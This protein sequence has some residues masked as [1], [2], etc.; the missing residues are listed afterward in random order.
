MSDIKYIKKL[1]NEIN[2][3]CDLYYNKNRP[4]ITDSEF[5]NLYDE[6]LELERV[7]GIVMSNSPTIN[8]GY[9][10]VSKLNKVEHT[11]PL[12]SLNKTK[13]LD[14]L[15]RFI[16]N[17]ECLMMLKM[18][19][20][21]TKLVYNDG[22]LKQGSTRGSGVIGEDITHSVK[23]F[24]NIP[25]KTN[26]DLTVIGESI[27]TFQDFNKINSTLNE[28]DKYRNP[29]NLASGSVRQLDSNICAK[30]N[31]KFIAYG[32]QD[33]IGKTKSDQLEYLE[34]LGFEVVPYFI[35]NRVNFED[36][37][38]I[39]KN[40][41]QE[42]GFAIDGLVISI[43]NISVAKNMGYT[44][45]F[46]KS[47]IALKFGDDLHETTFIEVEYN[48]TRTGQISLT[49]IFEPVEIDGTSVGRASLHN[50][51]IFESLQ[52]GKGDTILV[53]KANMIIPQVMDN[54]TRSNT[55]ELIDECPVCKNKAEVRHLKDSRQLF[56]TNDDCVA[57]NIG[58]I[59]HFVSRNSMNIVG[60]SEATIEKFVQCG[61]INDVADIYYLDD[62]AKEICKM[63]GFGRK[64]YEKL[65]KSIQ[66]STNVDLANFIN[67]LGIPNVGLSTA[68]T[69]AKNYDEI[70]FQHAN[71]ID[72]L[73]LDDIG[74]TVANSIVNWFKNDTNV[75][76]YAR[77][78]DDIGFNFKKN[79]VK[80]SSITGKSFV[81]TGSVNVFK[82]RKELQKRIEELGGVVKSS[83][84][85]DTDYLIN[86]DNMSSS[87]KNVTAK[88]LNVPII[89]EEEFIKL[90]GE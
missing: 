24:K 60:L 27:I 3:H 43:N 52:L 10:V 32:V 28:D 85:K 14:E 8:V 42:K 18:D 54:L 39:L 26:Y 12:L 66:D 57:K 72:L 5:D 89:T 16:G 77:L 69:L 81:V 84:S 88:K 70:S 34:A 55:V 76:L 65:V 71:K 53:R 83:V 59:A 7:T 4:E 63:N 11:F 87:S 41:A 22:D 31:V 64:S 23:T 29:R 25:L 82:N 6:L 35:V 20:L 48:T 80:E 19:G 30:R 78:V 73:V 47:A 13:S 44:S 17:H 2:R 37:I 36:K 67:A 33:D 49:G 40:I 79:E 46:P 51:D 86:N 1:V 62:Y 50:V 58:K 45:K 21:T 9:D 75:E 61:F 15:R 56:C 90:I 38:E 74:D 68:K